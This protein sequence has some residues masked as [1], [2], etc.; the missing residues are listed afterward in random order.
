MKII[1]KPNVWF[2]VFL[3]SYPIALVLFL[4][5]AL[6]LGIFNGAGLANKLWDYCAEQ[7]LK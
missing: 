2:T 5:H 1:Q 6:T 3:L 4:L 7:S